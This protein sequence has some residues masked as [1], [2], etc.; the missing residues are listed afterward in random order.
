MSAASSMKSS[1]SSSALIRAWMSSRS[2]GVTNVVLSRRPISW[3]ISSPRC[4]ASRISRGA[5]L[6]LVVGAEHRLEMAGRAEDVRG[7]LD[8]HVEEAL[9][10][11]DEAQSHRPQGSRRRPLGPR[12]VM[13]SSAVD[14]LGPVIVFV[15]RCRRSLLAVALGYAWSRGAHARGD[16][17]VAARSSPSA[18]PWGI[19]D[20]AR[21]GA[22]RRRPRS[23]RCAAPASRRGSRV[24]PGPAAARP[25]L[26]RRPR[27]ASGIVRADDD[28]RVEIA[29]TAAHVFLRPRAGLDRRPDG[30]RGLRR[31][32]VEAIAHGRPRGRLVQRR[33]HAGGRATGRA[34]APSS[35]APGARRS[36]ASGSSSRTSPSCGGS[37]ASGPSS[38]TTCRTS[39]AR[40]SR[41]SACS[42]S[43]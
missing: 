39:C 38:S 11:R 4:S 12:R 19:R 6:G 3:L 20:L 31:P 26:P 30:D 35:S 28:L 1:T 8:E 7:I 33:G 5:L 32:R 37:S 22:H 41:P 23:P 10:A 34:P 17:R 27:S 18:A 36:A 16:R 25:R 2:K 14:N 9:L 13:R 42:R 29:N 40:R 43:R 24:R 15:R 21:R